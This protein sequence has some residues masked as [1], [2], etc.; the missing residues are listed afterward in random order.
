[1][2]T[3]FRTHTTVSVLIT[4]LWQYVCVKNDLANVPYHVFLRSPS[5]SVQS[6]RSSLSVHTICWSTRLVSN[7]RVLKLLCCLFKEPIVGGG[8][9]VLCR[10]SLRIKVT[11]QD[12]LFVPHTRLAV[13][14]QLER[15]KEKR[16]LY[17][18][19]IRGS[20]KNKSSK[21]RVCFSSQ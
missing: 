10:D 17:Y 1:M 15:E 8:S 3:V 6:F 4:K 7:I 21:P 2:L 11:C 5:K 16:G 20:S 9:V 19:Y 14:Y 18:F 13:N 12:R